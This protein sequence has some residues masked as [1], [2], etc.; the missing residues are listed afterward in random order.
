M[1]GI[2]DAAVHLF[3]PESQKIC[4]KAAVWG[5]AF[6]DPASASGDMG[7]DEKARALR[8][9]N[10]LRAWDIGV[11]LSWEQY[12]RLAP[13]ALL[14]A[15]S[16]RHHHLLAIRI[17]GYLRLDADRILEHWACAKISSANGKAKEDGELCREIVGRLK[18]PGGNPGRLAGVAKLAWGQG[19]TRLATMASFLF[20]TLSFGGE[21]PWLIG[22]ACVLVAV[23][24]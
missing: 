7:L 9:M 22:I 17:A 21:R 20:L 23:E 8:V 3:E 16:A 19:R 12:I 13:G 5:R 24:P 15:L 11:G 1:L 2:L 4:L 14:D 18:H 10:A 6:L